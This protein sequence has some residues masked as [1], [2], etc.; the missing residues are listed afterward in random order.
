MF[1]EHY[2]KYLVLCPPSSHL[3][4]AIPVSTVKGFC[5]SAARLGNSFF[6]LSKLQIRGNVS[7]EDKMFRLIFCVKN[8]EINYVEKSPF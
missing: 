5:F 6:S 8:S 1:W 7:G 3:K 4:E 2:I